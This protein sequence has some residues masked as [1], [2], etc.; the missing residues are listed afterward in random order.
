[1]SAS[2]INNFCLQKFKVCVKINQMTLPEKPLDI[3]MIGSVPMSLSELALAP[4]MI[5]STIK[6]RGHRFEYFDINLD[7][8]DQCGRDN[9]VY[10]EHVEML[11]G[12]SDAT[13]DIIDAWQ[14]RVLQRLVDRDVVLINVF[15]HFSQSV[16][17]RLIEALRAAS[18]AQIIIGGIGSQKMI[19]NADNKVTKAWIKKKFQ[20]TRS[21]I[22]GKLLLVNGL[23]D[24]W[25]SDT[26][27]TELDRLIPVLPMSK[28]V[29]DVDFTVYDI[30]RYQW[31]KH[32]YVP[33]L[34]SH[35]CVRQCTFC[36]VIK[37]YPRYHFVE[38]DALTKQIVSIYDQ[39]G[40]SRFSFMDSLVNGSMSNFET[41]LRN[42]AHSQ[43]QGWLPDDFAWSGTYICRPPSTQ[44]D[45]IHSL[46]GA[47]GA[48]TL[49][50]GVE[51][52]S[53]RIRFEMDKKFTNDD[54]AAEMSAFA[55]AGIKARHLF[56]PAWPTETADDAQETLGL[57][58]MMQ[59]FAASGTL[60]SVSLGT[61]GFS[62][63]DGT[64]IDKTKHTIGLEAGPTPFLW[65]CSSN[66]TLDFWESLRRRM[67]MSAYCEHL[68]I[69]TVDESMFTRS[70]A[71]NLVQYRDIIREYVGPISQDLLDHSRVLETAPHKH[72][73]EFSVINSGSSD[74]TV[75]VLCGYERSVHHCPP[76][77]TKV[78]WDFH[79]RLDQHAEFCISVRFDRDHRVEWAQH[80]N[81]DYYDQRGVYLDNIAVDQ[82]DIT[83]WAFNLLATQH[84]VGDQELPVDYHAHINQRCVAGD[85]DLRWNV[86]AGLGIHAH[87][88][89]IADPELHRE[90]Q[91]ARNRLIRA[92]E[93]HA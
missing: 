33:V 58:R 1:M 43:Q 2:E 75:T 31:S 27:T 34:G 54:L 59:P 22:F 18:S 3:A 26:S 78:I 92:L 55:A 19:L 61:S 11:Q 37:H 42:L 14:S 71:F 68:G 40:I 50:I 35:G 13:D 69:V 5:S 93:S 4:A 30:D 53:D 70:L 91:Y 83:L 48:E 60:D 44:L 82:K 76:G 41:L 17:L 29:D 15:S 65:R 84:L 24:A 62:L 21:K 85:T 28:H 12:F 63:I 45:R 77:S 39:T 56:F 57:F 10:E 46:L 23:I 72:R 9:A 49:V 16:A 36:D 38:A 64:H 47:S 7:L 81:G 20:K 52:G 51:T 89:R 87:L 32:K 90:Y 80:H 66:P 79:K 8:F 73:M 74:V 25:Q 67:A 6:R 88:L 86:A